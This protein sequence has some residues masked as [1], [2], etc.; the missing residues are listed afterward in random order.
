MTGGVAVRPAAVTELEADICRLGWNSAL[1]D[2]VVSGEDKGVVE[3]ATPSELSNASLR[4]RSALLDSRVRRPWGRMPAAACAE[5]RFGEGN[6][7][8]QKSVRGKRTR[9][10][11][12]AGERSRGAA[13]SDGE[14]HAGRA[15]WQL[16]K[17]AGGLGCSIVHAAATI[18][19]RT[20]SS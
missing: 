12:V 5:D 16:L 8:S 19:T 1:V 2:S 14:I 4:A 3:V 9:G 11:A 7:R 10:S 13:E 17:T 6:I 20:G 15:I 18:S